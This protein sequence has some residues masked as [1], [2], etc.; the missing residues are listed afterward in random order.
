MATQQLKAWTYEDLL[1]LPDDGRRYEIIEGVLYEMP[2][3]NT[4]HA[5]LI[6]NLIELVFSPVVRAIGGRLFTAPVDVFLRG[7]SP[8]QPDL[9]VLLP[10]QLRLISKRGIEG[11][12]ALIV[13][14][15]SPGNPEHDLVTKRLLYARAGVAE[16]WLV[17]PEAALIE[18][19]AL[20][21]DHYRTHARVAG[22][23][24]LTSTVLPAL[25][26]PVSAVFT[27]AGGE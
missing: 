16:Y 19:L 27:L 4:D 8:V 11:A 2:A 6:M 26:C 12:P 17:S 20:D 22:D 21:G 1:T 13:E 14:V 9:L 15:L 25:S 3:P 7:A 23:D 18:I 10:G 24:L 5:Q